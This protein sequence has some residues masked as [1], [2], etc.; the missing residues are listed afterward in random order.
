MLYPAYILFICLLLCLTKSQSTVINNDVSKE[1]REPTCDG[2]F[3]AFANIHDKK[4]AMDGDRTMFQTVI[5]L[6]ADVSAAALANVLQF[7]YSG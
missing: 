4:V 7:L 6:R 3:P 2:H 5:E 1:S